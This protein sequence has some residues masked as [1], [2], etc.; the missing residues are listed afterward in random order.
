ML[1]RSVQGW[2]CHIENS[3]F[4]YSTSLKLNRH[5]TN[6]EATKLLKQLYTPSPSEQIAEDAFNI[7]HQIKEPPNKFVINT[8]VKVLFNCKQSHQIYSIWNDLKRIPNIGYIQLLKSCVQLKPINIDKC[9]EI[10][11]WINHRKYKLQQFE[12]ADFSINVSKLISSLSPEDLHKLKHI[13]SLIKNTNDVYIKTALINSFGKC[14][15]TET[16]HTIFNSIGDTQL[17][18]NCINSLMTVFI[19]NGQYENALD[20][21]ENDNYKHKIDN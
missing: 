20:L 5:L 12:I 1:S 8:L 2:Y 9:I 13:Y 14:N 10:L 3:I 16:A 7:Y 11:Q 17:D 4:F 19:S 6:S 21:Y 15:D 18:I